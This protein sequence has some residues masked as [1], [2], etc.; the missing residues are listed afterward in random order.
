[1][2]NKLEWN[3]LHGSV[4]AIPAIA[5]IGLGLIAVGSH[6]VAANP[7]LTPFNFKAKECKLDTSPDPVS[8]KGLKKMINGDTFDLLVQRVGGQIVITLTPAEPVRTR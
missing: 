2:S 6:A 7:A 4:L 5:L 8:C 3:P 1:M